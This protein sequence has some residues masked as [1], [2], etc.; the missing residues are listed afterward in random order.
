MRM[1]EV[2]FLGTFFAR[3]APQVAVFGADRL[4]QLH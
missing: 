1:K 4:F 3:T 2:V